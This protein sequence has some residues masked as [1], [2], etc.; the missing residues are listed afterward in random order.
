[1]PRKHK[2]LAWRLQ[3]PGHADHALNIQP[4]VNKGC[5]GAEDG[6]ATSLTLQ[7]TPTPT[8]LAAS[9]WATNWLTCGT[10]QSG[11]VTLT[12]TPAGMTAGNYRGAVRLTADG[13]MI[14]LPS[15][16]KVGFGIQ[17]PA[18][19]TVTL[20]A[21]TLPADLA[22]SFDVAL[23]AD[24]TTVWTAV[25]DKAWLVLG[26]GGGTGSET[27]SWTLDPTQLATMANWSTATATVTF[28]ATG[29]T[30]QT[31][32][33]MVQKALPEV[34][35][36]LPSTFPTGTAGSFT[37][38]GRGF[39]QLSSGSGFL[40]AGGSAVTGTLTSDTQ[41]ILQTGA[42]A[43]G[44][45]P[46]SVP[47]QVAMTPLSAELR[48][49]NPPPLAYAAVPF[50]LNV[51]SA[52]YDPSRSAVYA[53]SLASASL[54]KVQ[55][56]GGKWVATASPSLGAA[57]IRG[58]ALSPD[59]RS[60]C[61]LTQNSQ[62]GTLSLL[63]VDPDSLQ[64]TGTFTLQI[65][66]Y[67][68]GWLQLQ[69]TQDDRLWIDA[70]QWSPAAYFDLSKMAFGN[71][72][73][74]SVPSAINGM[75][76]GP[77]YFASGDGSKLL[78]APNEKTSTATYPDYVYASSTG[79]LGLP[80]TTPV[81][82]YNAVL[83]QDGSRVVFDGQDVYDGASFASLGQLLDAAGSSYMHIALI[84]PDGTRAY[85]PVFTSATQ[86]TVDHIDVFDT[87]TLVSES[88]DF[89]KVGTI[90]VPD[91]AAAAGVLPTFFM[92]PAGTTLFLMGSQNL[93]VV[94]IPSNLTA[95]ALRPTLR[96]LT[97]HP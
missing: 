94:P 1:M 6:D 11:A 48:V 73:L 95:Q 92:D 33:V 64:V 81:V 13:A 75:L 30:A 93:V 65:P 24:P 59:G 29:A 10:S 9:P 58:L 41:A 2:P 72:D 7:V 46:V 25:S 82:Q 47:L 31:T 90:Q 85:R 8:A 57:G 36:V 44:N 83:D 86:P 71:L 70:S 19:A 97:R 78:V 60:V 42:L 5:T 22:G 21:K 39:S 84:S 79:A 3:L 91:Q 37:V 88:P 54:Q 52:A 26:Q 14:I 40:V 69:A 27:L 16:F 43:Q 74:F 67:D 34:Y 50:P 18:S 63:L 61:V 62:I 32:Q 15:T 56:T 53:V 77:S 89:V 66:T 55:W 87:T 51:S 45:Y 12:A 76:W 23:A 17:A 38:Y 80:I 20:N 28:C 49:T 96:I 4:W 68:A 35:R